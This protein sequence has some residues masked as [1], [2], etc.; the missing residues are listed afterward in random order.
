MLVWVGHSSPTI[1]RRVLLS[2]YNN[3]N[4]GR[5]D[6]ATIDAQDLQMH[7]DV[8]CGDGFL[9][10]LGQDSGINQRGEKH[11]A[12][13]SGKA[14]EVCDAHRKCRRS[15]VVGR[16]YVVLMCEEAIDCEKTEIDSKGFCRFWR[17]P[18]MPGTTRFGQRPTTNG[19]RRVSAVC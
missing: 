4:L 2:V 7:A 15:L 11:V 13:D 9:E 1:S 16:T 18:T 10:K 17:L 6:A 12:A 5:T 8:E 14:I 19:Q 3:V